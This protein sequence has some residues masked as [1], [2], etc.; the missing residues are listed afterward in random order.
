MKFSLFALAFVLLLSASVSAETVFREPASRSHEQVWLVN[1]P[2][3]AAVNESTRLSITDVLDEG[4]NYAELSIG[5]TTSNMTRASNSIYSIYVTSGVEEDANW[6]VVLKNASGGVLANASDV[7]RFRVPF[8]VTFSFFR[9]KNASGVGFS[10]PYTD[11]F[12]YAV[13][14]RSNG[15]AASSDFSSSMQASI[16]KANRLL[17]GVYSSSSSPSYVF[18]QDIYLHAR[19]SSG[20]A[21]I[22]VFENGTYDLS[23]F[24]TRVYGGLTPLY[25]FGRPLATSNLEFRSA[26]AGDLVIAEEADAAYSVLISAW[27][28]Y[29]KQAFFNGFKIT[30][31]LVVWGLLAVLITFLITG[32]LPLDVRQSA[33]AAV[34]GVVTV[35]TLPLVVLGVRLL[36]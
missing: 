7:I 17:S 14:K 23:T 10:A 16:E 36:W 6:T 18:S 3:W 29:K 19:V 32:F 30:G 22:T 21:V 24:S 2:Y 27:G 13:L 26:V 11:E 12:Q 5:N 25:A 4:A 8:E 15:A 20:Q 28:V 9:D 31:L 33:F 35:A 1:Y 34:L